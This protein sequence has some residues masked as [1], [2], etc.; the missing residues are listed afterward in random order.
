ME[1]KQSRVKYIGVHI[2]KD[3]TWKTHVNHL[4]QTCLARLAMI[5]PAGHHLPCHT[6]KLLYQTFVLPNPDYCSVVWN[7]CGVMLS[8][9]VEQIQ[10]YALRLIL[11]KPP[12]TSSAE[13][14]V[15]LG[16]TTL[17]TRR[18]NAMLCQ[19]HRWSRKEAPSYLAC[20]FLTNSNLNYSTTRGANKIHLN[21]PNT[22]F[23]Q[24]T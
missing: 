22:N 20:K 19:V 24:S 14:R 4:R 17:K 10:N 16:W 21:R 7:S 23:Y 11:R 5:R 1:R 9:K 6:R 13:L 18:N 12:R 2:D 3:L 8:N 15:A